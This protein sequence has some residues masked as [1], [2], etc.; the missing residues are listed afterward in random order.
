LFW[1]EPEK[2]RA[3]VPQDAGK[4]PSACLLLASDIP[5][6]VIKT[7]LQSHSEANP[8]LRLGLCR[9]CNEDFL[10]RFHNEEE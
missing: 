9:N 10:V 3:E 4:T 7:D 5:R 2:Q 6:I 1:E 8:C